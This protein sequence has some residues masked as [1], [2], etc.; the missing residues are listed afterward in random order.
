[1]R[2][3]VGAVAVIAVLVALPYT[4]VGNYLLGRT[5][6]AI[7]REGV[8]PAI[9]YL[10]KNAPADVTVQS[11]SIGVLGYFSR[12]RVLDTMGLASPRSLTADPFGSERRS[13]L[14]SSRSASS[15]TTS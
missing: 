7:W 13:C 3:A 9:A 2:Y 15:R 5:Q 8:L 11:D 4:A 14:A 1:M 12:Y 10:D 6:D